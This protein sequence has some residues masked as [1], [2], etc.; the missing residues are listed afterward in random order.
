MAGQ[1]APLRAAVGTR[2]PVGTTRSRRAPRPPAA[3]GAHSVTLA[4]RAAAAAAAAV[5]AKV[6]WPSLPASSGIDKRFHCLP[7]MV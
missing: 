1:Q 5:T 3:G 6:D 7:I 2:L 4:E